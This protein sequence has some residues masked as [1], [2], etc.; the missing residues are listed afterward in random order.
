MTSGWTQ[1]KVESKI[2]DIESHLE[3]HRVNGAHGEFEI[4]R[5]NIVSKTLKAAK[6]GDCVN[7]AV[8]HHFESLVDEWV[9]IGFSNWSPP[10]PPKDTT[11]QDAFR[12]WLVEKFDGNVPSLKKGRVAQLKGEFRK[13]A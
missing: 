2:R 4:G 1:D 10:R 5:L 3:W 7:V 11:E 6:I 12:L 8:S 13:S 9:C